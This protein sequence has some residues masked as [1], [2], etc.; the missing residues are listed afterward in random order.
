MAATASKWALAVLAMA[1]GSAAAWPIS[2]A[3]GVPAL[4]CVIGLTLGG[5]AAF[6]VIRAFDLIEG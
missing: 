6:N 1:A 2:W 4:G 3:T 5:E